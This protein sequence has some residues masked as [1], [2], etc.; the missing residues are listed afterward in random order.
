M[1]DTEI[2][3]YLDSLTGAY[4]SRVILRDSTTGRGWRLNE[5]T[6]PGSTDKGVRQ[7]VESY[8]AEKEAILQSTEK[9]LLGILLKDSREEDSGP[10]GEYATTPG[11]VRLR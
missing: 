2:L 4:S 11:F 5:T 8:K 7:A 1:T 10:N 6:W 3:D 9:Y